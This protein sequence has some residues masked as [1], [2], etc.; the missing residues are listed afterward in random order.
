MICGASSTGM[1]MCM[2]ED[3]ARVSE[4]INPIMAAQYAVLK[5]I[6]H[7]ANPDEGMWSKLLP[8]SV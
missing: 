8:R 6:A 5:R 4:R 3:E 2:A 1:R 7:A